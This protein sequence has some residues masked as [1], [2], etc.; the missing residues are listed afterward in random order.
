MAHVVSEILVKILQT[1][2][3][4]YISVTIVTVVAMVTYEEVI[5]VDWYFVEE[6]FRTYQTMS[7]AYYKLLT[8]DFSIIW[9]YYNY[10]W[11]LCKCVVR[12]GCV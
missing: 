10:E 7:Y 4:A 1:S 3:Y 6:T 12:V 11:L 2:H 9:N 8:A 5:I